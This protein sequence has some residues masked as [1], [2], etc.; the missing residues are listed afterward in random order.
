[1]KKIYVNENVDH[2]LRLHSTS[3]ANKIV[4]VLMDFEKRL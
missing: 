1:M 3:G 4:H 2:V